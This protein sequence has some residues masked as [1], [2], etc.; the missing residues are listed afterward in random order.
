MSRL[1]KMVGAC[2]TEFEAKECK[3]T[4]AMEAELARG[5]STIAIQAWKETVKHRKERKNMGI[6]QL[7]GV[8]VCRL[9]LRILSAQ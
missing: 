2:A 8:L 5:H 1:Q 7:Q 3:I 4:I 9:P 6:P